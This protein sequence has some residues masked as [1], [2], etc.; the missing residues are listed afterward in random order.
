MNLKVGDTVCFTRTSKANSEGQIISIKNQN[1]DIAFLE[2]NKLK[3][4]CIPLSS[5]NATKKQ[6]NELQQKENQ[7]SK[8]LS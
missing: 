8:E 1:A 5:L 2:K 4:K 7:V 6:E 3:L